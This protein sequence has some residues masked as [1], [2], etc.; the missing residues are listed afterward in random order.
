LLSSFPL[1]ALSTGTTYREEGLVPTTPPTTY[2]DLRKAGFPALQAPY[3][4][5]IIE[6]PEH[7]AIA[8]QLCARTTGAYG[9][10]SDVDEV[11]LE[12]WGTEQ[13]E[14]VLQQLGDLAVGMLGRHRVIEALTGDYSPEVRA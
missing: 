2:D 13:P 12:L 7:R 9:V 3:F 6:R 5:R 11:S 14:H 8:V 1:P 4:Y 10:A